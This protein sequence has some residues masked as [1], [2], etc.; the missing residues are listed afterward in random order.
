MVRRSGDWNRA[1]G[2]RGLGAQRS[3]EGSFLPREQIAAALP[4]QLQLAESAALVDTAEMLVRGCLQR[5]QS[6]ELLTLEDRVRHR[7]ESASPR[8]C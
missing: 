3:D 5:V 1:R 7:R 6:G 2:D 4:M 8:A